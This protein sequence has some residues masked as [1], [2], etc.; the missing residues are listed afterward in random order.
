MIAFSKM[1]GLGND[2]I[3]IDNRDGSIPEAD[4]PA[5]A[6]KLCPRRISVGADGILMLESPKPGADYDFRMRYLNPDGSEAMCGN[7][8]RCI[9]RFAHIL[10]AIDDEARF[11]GDD[12]IHFA[13]VNNDDVQIDLKPPKD[14]RLNLKIDLGQ[15]GKFEVHS[16]NTGVPHAVVFCCDPGIMDVFALGRALRY[17]EEFVPAGANVNFV[18][19]TS[20]N[21]I[22]I[23]TYE[24]GVEEETLACGTG[25]TAAALVAAL[26]DK[27]APPVRV[28]TKSGGVLTI[29]FEFNGERIDKVFLTGNA[30]EVYRGEIKI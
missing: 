1:S 23:R 17:H 14:I 11:L 24:R 5:I 28:I 26:L 3:A 18:C 22:T 15:F 20:D 25:A 6:G 30:E 2:F 9:V 16:I 10:G 29:D 7:G 27:V 13:R 8:A 12:G 4:Y 21:S 19:L